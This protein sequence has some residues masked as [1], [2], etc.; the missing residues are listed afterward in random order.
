MRFEL[1]PA[2][3]QTYAGKRVESPGIFPFAFRAA[4]RFNVRT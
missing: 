1:V 4:W 2:K 3:I